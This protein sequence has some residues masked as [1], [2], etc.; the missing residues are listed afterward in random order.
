MDIIGKRKLYLFI[1]LLILIPGIIS[2]IRWGLKPGIDFRGGQEIELSHEKAIDRNQVEHIFT[3]YGIDKIIITSSDNS[4]ILVRY[5]DA[6]FIA[7]KNKDQKNENDKIDS[8]KVHNGLK[9]KLSEAGYKE[10]SYNS[11]GSS[12]SETL[13]QNAILSVLIASIFIVLYISFA[14]RNTPPPVSP[15]SFGVCAVIA[16]LHDALFVL[17]TFSLLGHYL[18]VEID[19]FF[20]TAVLTVIGFSVHDTIVVFDRVRENLKRMSGS[21]ESIVNAS[22]VETIGRS[23]ATSITVMITL[24]AL[25]IF[26]GASIRH[27]IFALLIGIISG[28]YS[29]IFNAAPMLVIWNNFIEKRQNRTSK[30]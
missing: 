29:S 7:K 19:S 17:G 18:N 9:D 27:F 3:S 13:T 2:L 8:P 21:F 26:G 16:L 28:T 24:S 1:S 6:D 22:I 23:I 5:S 30:S 25:L 11:V 15:L 14:F 4:K 20:V 10:E 12:V